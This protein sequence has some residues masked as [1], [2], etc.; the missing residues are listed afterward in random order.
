MRL[1][2][3]CRDGRGDFSRVGEVEVT[4]VIL[5]HKLTDEPGPRGPRPW[6][7]MGRHG[8]SVDGRGAGGRA[9]GRAAR[10]GI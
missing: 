7:R 8:G 6:S 10:G 2:T 3:G 1:H 9:E 5:N 4:E